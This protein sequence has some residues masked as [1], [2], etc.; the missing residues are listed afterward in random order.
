MSEQDTSEATPSES[1]T[2]STLMAAREKLGLS[3]K[4]VAD[5]L[6][7]TTTFIR[8]IDDGEFSKLPKPAFVKGYLRTYARV[9][10]LSGDDI[11]ELYESEIEASDPTPEIKGVTEEQ[12][13]TASITG[14]VL[15]TGLF[16]LAC[17]IFVIGVVWFLVSGDDDSEDLPVVTQSSV[18]RPVVSSRDVPQARD[19][20][21]AVEST[22]SSEQ[23]DV[24]GD[25]TPP[26]TATKESIDLRQEVVRSA[27]PTKPA[28]T[29]PADAVSP[30]DASGTPDAEDN[31]V[32]IERFTQGTRRYVTVNAGG[33]DQMELS[34][35]D[36]C[37]VEITDAEQGQIYNDLNR[38]A[39]VLTVYGT[40]PFDVL[41]GKATGVEMLYNG[42][43]FD[44]EPYI[45]RDRTAK[46]SVSE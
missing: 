5:K 12:V 15:Q 6:F 36:E 44:L 27:T 1:L 19:L 32:T 21:A 9:V 28:E 39:D 17:L 10:G 7:L 35:T 3:Q 42:Q 34:F 4:E 31:E 22:Q 2:A 40:A 24:A 16:G 37:W 23:A 8:Y 45:S 20:P 41:L 30:E 13:G 46:L 38:S 14:P 18:P 29:K 26:A 43:P 11:V 25:T 33:F